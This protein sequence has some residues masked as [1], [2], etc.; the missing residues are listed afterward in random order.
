MFEEEAVAE[1]V[2]YVRA[3]TAAGQHHIHD[4]LGCK[5]AYSHVSTYTAVKSSVEYGRGNSRVYPDSPSLLTADQF[6]VLAQVGAVA[7]ETHFDD[8]HWEDAVP[9][10][11]CRGRHVR[12]V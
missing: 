4:S 3:H 12:G 5:Q 9:G 8:L 6:E 7:K 10:D 2:F 11:V 1:A